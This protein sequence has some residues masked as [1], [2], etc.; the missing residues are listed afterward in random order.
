VH[1]HTVRQSLGH[2]SSIDLR[3]SKE[4]SIGTT[5]WTRHQLTAIVPSRGALEKHQACCT[6]PASAR[7][8]SEHPITHPLA[9]NMI[10]Q[11]CFVQ[12]MIH[13]Q[14]GLIQLERQR[15]AP[16]SEQLTHLS[17]EHHTNQTCTKVKN[18]QH[19]HNAQT[20]ALAETTNVA[21]QLIQG[22]TTSIACTTHSICCG[23][24]ALVQSTPQRNQYSSKHIFLHSVSG[25]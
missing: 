1:E 20:N 15:G 18:R 22:F 8:E 5:R 10:E 13:H 24:S 16:S 21:S 11:V 12:A 19:I 3:N 7:L 14:P 4:A 2:Q 6:T 9:S 23:K 25:A 17:I